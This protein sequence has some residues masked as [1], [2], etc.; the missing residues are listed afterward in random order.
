MRINEETVVM[1]CLRT[2][3]FSSVALAISAALAHA[4]D[5]PRYPI[6]PP[7]T[8]T[9]TQLFEETGSGW[10]LRGDV[11]YRFQ[12]VKSASD[13]LNEYSDNSIKNAALFG[14]GVGYKWKWFRADLTGDYGWRS[15]YNGSNTT[16]AVSGKINTAAVL[17]N[18]YVDLGTWGGFTPYL[19]AGIGGAYVTLSSYE[20]TPPQLTD[21][22]PVSR[23]NVAWAAMAGVSYNL[24]DNLAVDVGYR[25]IDFGNVIGGPTIN[26]LTIKKLTGDEVR[27]G[28]RY[29]LD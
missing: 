28:L 9:K 13:L 20:T 18:G 25:H 27:I 15:Q 24:M 23:W 22:A 2:L 21:I 26:Q 6:L 4:A 14:G 11:G 17:F 12:R 29:L 19:G 7:P 3:V 16:N 1:G 5:M 10:Y 8:Q